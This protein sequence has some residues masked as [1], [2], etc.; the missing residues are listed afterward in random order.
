MNHERVFD[1]DFCTSG[2]CNDLITY[3]TDIENIHMEVSDIKPEDHF[4]LRMHYQIDI[5]HADV[6]SKFN[7]TNKLPAPNM[8][9]SAHVPMRPDPMSMFGSW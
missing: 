8:I 9:S 6:K 5:D 1:F 4:Y 3:S 2:S 7:E